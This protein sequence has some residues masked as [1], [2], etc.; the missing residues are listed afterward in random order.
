[1]GELYKFQD[2][3]KTEEGRCKAILSRKL[4]ENFKKVRLTVSSSLDPLLRIKDNDPLG[5]SLEVSASSGS[6][7]ITIHDGVISL[8]TLPAGQGLL[9]IQDGIISVVAIPSGSGLLSVADGVISVI[10]SP[11]D[12]TQFLNGALGFTASEECPP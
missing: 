7:I 4:D 12:A 1:M 10:A 6:Y 3:V 2:A 8:T 5:D 9:S 11:G